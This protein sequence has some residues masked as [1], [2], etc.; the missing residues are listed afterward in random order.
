MIT[1]GMAAVSIAEAGVA[2]AR[3][4]ITQQDPRP[5][6]ALATGNGETMLAELP[7]APKGKRLAAIL[8]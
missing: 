1:T 2:R 8:R 5:G 6:A 3:E 4:G 7:S